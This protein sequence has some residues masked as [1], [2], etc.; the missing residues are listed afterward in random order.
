MSC[1][2]RKC[3]FEHVCPAKS[4]ISLHIHVVWSESSLGAFWMAKDAKFLH[5]DKEDSDQTAPMHRL[6]SVLVGGHVRRYI[7]SL[8]THVFCCFCF[9]GTVL[10]N[11]NKGKWFKFNDTV[12][13]EFEMSDTTV[14]AE[15]FGGTYKAKVY[16]NGE[17]KCTVFILSIWTPYLLSI[18]VLKFKQVHFAICWC[19]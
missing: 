14:E 6:I 4:Q 1:N 10:N 12:V 7:F 15:C 5:A 8:C 3:T 16:D 17:L 9:R 18:L 19:V 2:I 13:E 11:N